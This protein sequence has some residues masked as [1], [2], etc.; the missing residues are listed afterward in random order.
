MTQQ[1][2]TSFKRIETK[3]IIAK[4]NLPKVIKDLKNYLV[5]DDYPTSTISNVY[6][7]TEDFDVIQD[8]LAKQNRREKI[9]MRTY[10]ENPQS[11]SQVFLEI[12]SKDEDGVGHK[13]RLVSNSHSITQL[14]TL[15]KI[16]ETITDTKLVE[17]IR[18]LR[19][20]YD[21]G[22]KP[23]MYIYYDRFSMK[24][25]KTNLDLPCSKVRVTIDQNLT[26]RD[27][28]VSL[29][30]GNTGKPLLEDDS[31]IMEIKAAGRKPQWLQ[32]ILDK[33]GLVEQKFS[34]YS[35]AYHKSQGLD[36]APRPNQ[37]SVGNLYV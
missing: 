37:E 34:K 24:E 26:Y 23:R 13:Y 21:N 4:E 29:F 36:Y 7:D 10:L 14:L 2:E 15:G 35:C 6:F 20:R 5:E 33:H 3:Y 8:A 1:F 12:K 30:H 32:T 16:D 17:E 11:D 28:L 22:L 19:H 18:Q 27:E 9:R 25:R 31:V